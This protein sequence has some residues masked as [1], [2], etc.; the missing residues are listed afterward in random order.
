MVRSLVIQTSKVKGFPVVSPS[1]AI[2]AA[3]TR[4]ALG[5]S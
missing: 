2:W 1:A 3:A 5:A 4:A